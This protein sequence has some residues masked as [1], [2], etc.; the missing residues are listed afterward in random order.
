MENEFAVV[1][2][3]SGLLDFV[4]SSS[5]EMII[6]GI[7]VEG[8]EVVVVI[9]VVGLTTIAVAVLDVVDVAI[10]VALSV[11]GCVLEKVTPFSSR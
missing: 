6:D 3:G 7:V 9:V 4:I 10:G 11:V 5:T 2:C 8:N 1:F